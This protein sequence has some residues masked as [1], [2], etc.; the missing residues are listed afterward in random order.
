MSEELS[1][2][3][4]RRAARPSNSPVLPQGLL[5]ELSDLLA[6]GQIDFAP[7]GEPIASAC[8]ESLSEVVRVLSAQTGQRRDAQAVAQ[9]VRLAV[10][11]QQSHVLARHG[12][13]HFA[14]DHLR[15]YD[16]NLASGPPSVGSEAPEQR[17]GQ[18]LLIFGRQVKNRIGVASS[19]ITATE[20]YVRYLFE[21]GYGSVTF[22]TVR[23]HAN[24]GF[25]QPTWSFVDETLLPS[26]RDL[27]PRSVYSSLD[28][29][30][31]DLDRTTTVN[32][33]GVPSPDPAV[34]Q[35][36]LRGCLASAEANQ[37][38]IAS[39]MGSVD[40]YRGQSF[41]RDFA[42]AAVLA[43]ETGVH[44]I[45]LN[46]SCP[47]V[48]GLDSSETLCDRPS[49]V[50]HVVEAVRSKLADTTRLILKLGPT[51]GW[52]I[53]EM[54]RIVG[55]QIA[56]VSGINTVPVRVLDATGQ[57]FFPRTG[58]DNATREIAGLSGAA[59]K[60]AAVRFLRDVQRA[61][62]DVDVDVAVVGMG[63]V[64]NAKDYSDFV[65]NGADLVHSVT[66]VFVNPF[67]VDEC[68]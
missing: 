4:S 13:R 55:Q 64:L 2:G 66:G 25:P 59:I 12:L 48:V 3:R 14:F 45:E 10:I 6:D 8:R 27:I 51:P 58:H 22:K 33:F 40:K 29:L 68:V 1:Y 53:E 30:P 62:S 41:I 50:G 17:T 60:H 56:G 34:W 39:V 31:K 57:Q 11:G 63:G 32:S 15:S 5:D 54:L 7:L 42:K 35:E 38:L 61:K 9:L 47:N 36:Q 49:E 18:G 28:I 26:N 16:D 20:Q 44:V 43:E 19:V 24:P 46:L 65:D 52:K 67:L 23:T 21:L 37:L